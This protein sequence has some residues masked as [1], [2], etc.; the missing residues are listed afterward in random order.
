MY[1]KQYRI[2]NGYC[3]LRI[4]LQIKN[5]LG[6]GRKI[7]EMKTSPPFAMNIEQLT[8]NN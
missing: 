5:G 3:V 1:P 4:Q 2:S 8:M 7:R 6:L